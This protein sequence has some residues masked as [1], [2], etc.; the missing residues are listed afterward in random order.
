MIGWS[1]D[2]WQLIFGQGSETARQLTILSTVVSVFALDT[3]LNALMACCRCLIVDCLPAEKQKIAQAYASQVSGACQLLSYVL[4]TTDVHNLFSW[5]AE[6]QF[7]IVLIYS[8]AAS[9]FGA[10]LTCWAVEERILVSRG[11]DEARQDIF[12][13]LGNILR[14]AQTLPPRIRSICFAQILV[15]HAWFPF[16]FYSSTWMGEV[17]AKSVPD[18]SLSADDKSRAGSFGMTMLSIVAMVCT[19]ILPHFTAES[20]KRAVENGH[21]PTLAKLWGI[22]QLVFGVAMISTLYIRDLWMA[23]AIVCVCG[24]CSCVSHWAP[25]TLL[26][27]EIQHL[28]G[29]RMRRTSDVGHAYDVVRVV[30]EEELADDVNV[31]FNSTTP[32]GPGLER[33][34]TGDAISGKKDE[35]GSILGIH[36]I[37]VCIPQFIITFISSIV[38][39]LLEPGAVDA[40]AEAVKAAAEEAAAKTIAAPESAGNASTIPVVFAIG[41]FFALLAGVTTLRRL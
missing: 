19:L 3:A 16:L 25:F 1:Y 34:A 37:A 31:S 40:T 9:V 28:N 11:K 18:R 2:A 32:L 15:W 8:A 26:G 12:T 7:K 35:A 23:Y 4:G 39:R 29:G 36:N 13:I 5:L 24:F 21:K 17:Y 14:T 38:F 41:G 30:D 27:E 6:S 22:S 33:P 20:G 10:I